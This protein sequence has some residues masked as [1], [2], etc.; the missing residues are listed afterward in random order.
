MSI[1]KEIKSVHF[2]EEEQKWFV[3]AWLTDKD[4]E[5]GKV[6]AKVD[7]QCT[8]E[9]I[10]T[11]AKTDTYTQEIIEAARFDT[12][13]NRVFHLYINDWCASRGYDPKNYDAE[14]G[15]NGESFA[16]FDEFINAEFR[17][18]AYI[19]HLLGDD[20]DLWLDIINKHQHSPITHAS[21]G[22]NG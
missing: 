7:L 21:N 4:T 15:F 11:R 16:C 18:E 22:G 6:I 20:I 14:H 5:E 17:D 12:L 1:W 3:D 9:Y 8:V 19:K 2:D 13:T 10:D